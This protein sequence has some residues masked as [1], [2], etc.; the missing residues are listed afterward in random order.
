MTLADL[1]DQAKRAGL[2]PRRT[3][4]V[5]TIAGAKLQQQPVSEDQLAFWNNDRPRIDIR[6]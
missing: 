4:I 3:E 5:C 6:L 1:N 2:D